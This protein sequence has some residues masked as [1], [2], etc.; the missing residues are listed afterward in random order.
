MLA[1]F[2]ELLLLYEI[3]MR[4]YDNVIFDIRGRH[5]MNDGWFFARIGRTISSVELKK[6]LIAC[7]SPGDT[8]DTV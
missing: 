1:Q 7:P 3:H 5:L 2:F 4:G 8:L 6:V